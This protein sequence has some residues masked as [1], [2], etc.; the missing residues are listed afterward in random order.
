MLEKQC[1]H[2]KGLFAQTCQAGIC[3]REL[4][5]KPCFGE[6]NS[7]DKY[8]PVAQ[9]LIDKEKAEAKYEDEKFEI[10]RPTLE[11]IV[12]EHKDNA[13]LFGCGTIPCPFCGSII[14]WLYSDMGYF[15][16]KGGCQTRGCFIFT[17]D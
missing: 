11:G 8:V 9:E 6:N 15:Q 1:Q 17:T 3:H 4:N 16:F 7:C 14:E 5:S 10:M 13:R 12:K 2:W